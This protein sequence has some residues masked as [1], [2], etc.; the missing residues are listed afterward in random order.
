MIDLFLIPYAIFGILL[1]SR[2]HIPLFMF[3]MD[4]LWI[5]LFCVTIIICANHCDSWLSRFTLWRIL[6][7]ILD[8]GDISTT[9]NL[10]DIIDTI[11]CSYTKPI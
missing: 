4:S 1:D 3:W 2:F 7:W 11:I 5:V 10:L 6:I 8:L 9:D